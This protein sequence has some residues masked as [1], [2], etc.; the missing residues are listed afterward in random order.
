[1]GRWVR[2]EHGFL[3]KGSFSTYSVEVREEYL[4]RLE[5]EKKELI[6]KVKKQGT[7]ESFIIAPDKSIALTPQRP[8]LVSTFSKG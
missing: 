4:Y 1:M 7:L 5:G 2:Y 8:L 6:F 3:V